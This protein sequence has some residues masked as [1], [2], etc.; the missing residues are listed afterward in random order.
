[1]L[2][3]FSKNTRLQVTYFLPIVAPFSTTFSHQNTVDYHDNNYRSLSFTTTNSPVLVDIL[4][5]MPLKW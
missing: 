2:K 5:S 3:E 4:K 1:M